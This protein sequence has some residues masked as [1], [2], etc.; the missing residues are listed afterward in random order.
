MELTVQNVLF[1]S[2]VEGTH[3][4]LLIILCNLFWYFMNCNRIIIQ[5][6]NIMSYYTY[7]VKILKVLEMCSNKLYLCISCL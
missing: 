1:L 4:H 6:C 7:H 3:Y 5:L 2:L